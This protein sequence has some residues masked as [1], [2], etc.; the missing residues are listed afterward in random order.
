SFLHSYM[1]SMFNISELYTV[2]RTTVRQNTLLLIADSF[3]GGVGVGDGIFAEIYDGYS[4]AG[5]YAADSGNLL[6]EI[7]AELGV[8]GLIVFL[9]FLLLI[10]IKLFTSADRREGAK[11][12]VLAGAPAA[13]IIAVIFCGMTGYIW[14]DTMMFLGFC[15]ILGLGASISEMRSSP[16]DALIVSDGRVIG[17]EAKIHGHVYGS[18]QDASIDIKL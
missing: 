14:S 16:S 12:R 6:L 17:R 3:F 5:A 11:A 10:F 8:S 4:A 9:A 2:M 7:T 1:V 13:G 18:G 15:M